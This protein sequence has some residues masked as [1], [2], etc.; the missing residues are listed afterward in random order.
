M[1][2]G[3]A[4]GAVW[5][6]A[7]SIRCREGGAGMGPLGRGA[8]GSVANARGAAWPMPAPSASVM[9]VGM[10]MDQDSLERILPES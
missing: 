7:L 8:R 6:V 5:T 2:D 9:R 3:S 10:F 1:T 4:P